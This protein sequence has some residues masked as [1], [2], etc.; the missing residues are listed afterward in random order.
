MR[1]FLMILIVVVIKGFFNAK[2]QLC[3][4][5]EFIWSTLFKY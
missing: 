1:Q 3:T 2:I 5:F 4:E